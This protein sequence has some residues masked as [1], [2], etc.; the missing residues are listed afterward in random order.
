MAENRNLLG[1]YQAIADEVTD[2]R[3]REG[4]ARTYQPSEPFERL[5]EMMER[6]P[7]GFERLALTPAVKIELGMYINA[8]RAARAGEH[9]PRTRI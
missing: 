9:E 5:L 7:E 8:K 1:P 2:F 6:D 4:I 3:V